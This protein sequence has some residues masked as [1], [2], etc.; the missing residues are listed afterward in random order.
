M[1]ERW[2]TD[3]TAQLH[4]VLHLLDDDSEEADVTIMGMDTA[5][6]K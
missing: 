2:I 5:R 4:S 1:W 3:L 6:K